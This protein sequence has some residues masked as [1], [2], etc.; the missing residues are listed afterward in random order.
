MQRAQVENLIADR[1]PAAK[2]LA[3]AGATEVG[4]RQVL[5]RE[6]GVRRVGRRYP[7]LQTRIMGGVG[8][9]RITIR[10]AV[11]HAAEGFLGVKFRFRPRHTPS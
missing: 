11:T 5:D 6:V 9:G 10:A 2:V 7:T 8:G 3:R 1:R 4:E